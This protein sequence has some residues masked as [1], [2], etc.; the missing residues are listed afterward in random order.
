MRA[1]SSFW[2]EG[3]EL[4]KVT[5]ITEHPQYDPSTSSDWDFSILKLDYALVYDDNILEIS[6]SGAN[7]NVVG[8]SALNVTRWSKRANNEITSQLQKIQVYALNQKTCRQLYS[9]AQITDQMFC[10]GGTV[11]CPGGIGGSVV[12]NDTL[13]GVVSGRY[14]CGLPTLPGAYGRVASVVPWINKVAFGGP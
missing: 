11:P 6:L 4:L 14:G 10:A 7:E 3:G 13:F 1:G 5:E 9:D 2:D 8:A 12:Q